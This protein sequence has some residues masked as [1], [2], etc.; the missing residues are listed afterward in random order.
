MKR[1]SIH[2]FALLWP[3]SDDYFG[4]DIYFGF[5]LSK[6]FNPSQASMAEQLGSWRLEDTTEVVPLQSTRK[7]KKHDRKQLKPGPVPSTIVLPS[8]DHTFRRWV[9]GR[10]SVSNYHI[11]LKQH[12]RG[13][14]ATSSGWTPGLILYIAYLQLAY[15]LRPQLIFICNNEIYLLSEV[16]SI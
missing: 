16:I 1:H 7:Q 14:E 10:H 13:L 5:K 9:H 2:Y 11:Y 3:D 12:T 4:G 8:E 6:G 15:N